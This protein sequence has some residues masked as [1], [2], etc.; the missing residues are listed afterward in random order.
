MSNQFIC[1]EGQKLNFKYN[2]IRND[3][4]GSPVILVIMNVKIVQIV[5]FDHYAQ[6]PRRIQPGGF[7]K[8]G[9]GIL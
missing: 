4:Y 1:P 2:G 9:L 5:Q 8:I 6:K 3:K 7:K